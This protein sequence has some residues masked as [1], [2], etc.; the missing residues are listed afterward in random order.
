MNKS[1]KLNHFFIRIFLY[2]IIWQSYLV[3]M[4]NFSPLGTQ[5]LSW[6]NQRIFNF[7]EFLNLNGLNS[8]N[9]FSIWTSCKDC[10]LAA[11]SWKNEIYLSTTFLP[12][13]HYFLINKFFGYESLKFFGSIFDKSIIFLTGLILAEFLNLG[14][15][16]KSSNFYFS[17]K[18]ILVFTFFTVNPWT[19]KMFLSSWVQI[20]F[21]F[22]FLSG[23]YLFFINKTY[24]GLIFFLFSGFLIIN[25]LLGYFFLF[26]S[27]YL[28]IN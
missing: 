8:F 23:V 3:F 12:H 2:I 15:K 28:F 11:N 10:N 1:I 17:V 25:L 19:Y 4:S 9:G 26:S 7:S 21:V 20:Y 22:F 5:W 13:F 27:Y 18:S 6:H 24:L 14:L 16:N